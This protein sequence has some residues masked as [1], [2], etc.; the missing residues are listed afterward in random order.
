MPARYTPAP[1]SENNSFDG[2]AARYE[3]LLVLTGGEDPSEVFQLR[4]LLLVAGNNPTAAWYVDLVFTDVGLLIL[5][6]S[7]F[8]PQSQ[9]TITGMSG[10]FGGVLGAM[11]AAEEARRE[12]AE[13]VAKYERESAL[14]QALPPAGRFAEGGARSRFKFLPKELFAKGVAD[15]PQFMPA[16][17]LEPIQVG[18]KQLELSWRGTTYCFSTLA[19]QEAN[20]DQVEHWQ[21][22]V[23]QLESWRNEAQAV[24]RSRT[25]GPKESGLAALVEW[26]QR[27][28]ALRPA[29]GQQTI[30]TVS[31]SNLP[32][33][34]VHS[35]PAALLGE[36]AGELT[37]MNLVEAEAL[38]D[39]LSRAVVAKSN[40]YLLGGGGLLLLGVPLAILLVNMPPSLRSGE[41]VLPL[42]ILVVA[43]GL[44]A[45][46]LGG[47]AV[48]S[49]IEFWKG[50]KK[51]TK[52][53]ASRF[54]PN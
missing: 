21:H 40:F 15:R 42:F 41:T 52:R 29:W 7:W 26:L 17:E 2:P 34:L 1:P 4:K 11:N 48:T 18:E 13:C 14:D 43:L 28:E 23:P 51:I 9:A 49:R 16:D 47:L 25:G 27:P 37:N 30:R 54:K 50:R 45:F 19:F 8:S 6:Y 22:V 32:G 31:H 24:R 33:S 12:I 36:L 3:R 35:I 39:K 20:A 46:M 10:L 53:G 38:R 44:G 5:P